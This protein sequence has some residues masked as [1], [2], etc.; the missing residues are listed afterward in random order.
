MVDFR[1][2]TKGSKLAEFRNITIVGVGLIG[3]SLG[4]AFKRLDRNLR[5]AGVGQPATL[6]RAKELG[7][8][9]WSFPYESLDLGVKNADI[10]FFCTPIFRILELLGEVGQ[11]AKPGAL[12]TDVGSTKAEIAAA[13]ER[14]LPKGLFFIGGHPMAG[15]EKR[16]VDAADPLLF[17]N[18]IYVL[19]PGKDVPLKLCDDF[20]SL[21]EGIGARVVVTGPHTH[22]MVAAAV[23]H[24]PQMI[25]VGL[26]KMVGELDQE[27][28]LFLRLAA[29]GFRDL[30]RIA[31]SSYKV[32][33]DIC[34]TNSLQI[35]EMID[36]F[37]AEL[38][39]LRDKVSTGQLEEDFDF[40]NLTRGSIPKDS[41]G[42]LHPLYEILVVVEDR[43]GVIAEISTTIAQGK[44]NIKDIEVLK[45]R[46]GEAGTLR[47]AFES[48]EAAEQA[49]I[50]LQQKGIAARR[51]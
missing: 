49:I 10:V 50:L 16:G 45:V 47:L 37:I 6:K 25:A 4:L 29:G 21:V 36:R 33:K 5:I 44:I 2:S 26:V 17:Q 13:A 15:S 40:A 46:E 8:I 18:V 48:E 20:A 11:Y 32:W 24:L 30:T 43:P 12:I 3:G 34:Q 1:L 23:S 31:S 51:R 39:R 42:F 41:K 19:T 38:Q 9:D 14:L 27:N 22:D 7:A 35:T 28:P